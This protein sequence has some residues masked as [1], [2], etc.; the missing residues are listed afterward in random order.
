[1]AEIA[2]ERMDL[3]E[4]NLD[5]LLAVLEQRIQPNLYGRLRFSPDGSQL[6]SQG[7]DNSLVLWDLNQ[8]QSELRNLNLAW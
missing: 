8:L 2:D 4:V 5:D 7:T 6:A 3:E 1:M